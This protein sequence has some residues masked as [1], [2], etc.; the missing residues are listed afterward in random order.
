M[1][2]SVDKL[3]ELKPAKLCYGHFGC[4]D[5]GLER[6]KQYREKLVTW[7]EIVIEE[8]GR[9][10]KRMKYY[11]FL[12]RKTATWNI[13]TPWVRM[14]TRGNWYYCSIASAAWHKAVR[15]ILIR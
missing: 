6:L 2:A 1:L 10:K 14:N 15:G 7:N 3:I 8:M 5:H 12:E 9:V 11:L 13:L 4:Y